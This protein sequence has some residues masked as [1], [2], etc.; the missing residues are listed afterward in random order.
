MMMPP[1]RLLTG[2]FLL[3]CLNLSAH[4]G[5]H[6]SVHDTVAGV[7]ERMKAELS[8]DQLKKLDRSTV[9]GLLTTEE[10]HILATEHISFRVNLPVT[11]SV[12]RDTTLRME[13]FWLLEEGFQTNGVVLKQGRWQFDIWEKEFPAGRVGLGINSLAGGGNHYFVLLQPLSFEKPLEVSD[14]YP[15]QL[16]VEEFRPGVRPYVD[17]AD[18]IESIPPEL[19]HRT[20]LRTAWNWR[21]AAKLVNLF[22]WTEHPSSERPDHV[23]LT[24]SEDPKTTQTIQW[25]TGPQSDRGMVAFQK[26]SRFNRFSPA[27]LQTVE[28]ATEPLVT[29]LLLNDPVIH[30]HTA[31]LRGLDP[32]TSYVYSV[33]NGGPEDWTELAEFTTAPAGVEPFSFIYM[34]DAQ[35]GLHRWGSLIHNAFRERPDAAFYVMAGDLV[36]RGAERDDW[37]CLFHNAQGVYDRRQLVPAIGNHECHGGHPTLYLKQLEL[38]RNGPP[39]IEPE[40]VYA[41]E[42]SNALF[43]I[44]DSNLKP[45]T[46]T[47]WIEEQL[48]R[49]KATWKFVVYHH[50]AYSSAANRDNKELREKWT[51]LF[52]KYHVDMA[53][54]GHDH[55]YLRTFPMKGQEKAASAAEGTIYIVSVSGTK[56]YSQEERDY[57]EFGLTNVATYQVL[58]I[59]ISG[60]RLVYRAY[61]IDG[62]LRDELVLTK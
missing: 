15:G 44:L 28:A 33:G 43:L 9:D 2:F 4:V 36:N 1:V 29:P 57:T 10:R 41:L 21:D 25:R 53:L 12:L 52:D 56:M 7:I 23:I 8:Q 34:G 17:R 27:P 22:R 46:Q 32:G 14:L 49:T 62:N 50:P 6:A 42:Y 54:Q 39:E 30:R 60:D 3:L 13:P 16:R 40:R 24:W 45:E 31:V 59:Q 26:K 20:L 19:E 51:P 55:A 61:D 47:A 35:N 38:L 11:V 5:P 48:S 18:T 58:D 37:D